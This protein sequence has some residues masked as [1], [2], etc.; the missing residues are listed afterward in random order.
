MQVATMFFGSKACACLLLGSGNHLYQTKT[1]TYKHSFLEW[2]K[3]LAWLFLFFLQDWVP[4]GQW[5]WYKHPLMCVVKSVPYIYTLQYFETRLLK[6]V[7]Y[8][9]KRQCLESERKDKNKGRWNLALIWGLRTQDVASAIYI[10][11][12]LMYE[13]G[14]LTWCVLWNIVLVACSFHY[15]CVWW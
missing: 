2:E 5:P 8:I 9:L 15:T 4:W 12:N 3:N 10:H 7:K 6:L 13:F 11:K 14:F 1:S